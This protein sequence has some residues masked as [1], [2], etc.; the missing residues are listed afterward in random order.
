M[1]LDIYIRTDINDKIFTGNY[2]DPKQGY[3]NK[4]SL[5]RTFCNFMCRR[6]VTEGESELDQI[7]RITLVDISPIYQMENYGSDSGE[8]LEFLLEVAESEEER[9]HILEQA[10]QNKENLKGNLDKV[11]STI[12]LLIGKLSKINDLPSLLDDDGND[13]LGYYTYFIDF[14]IDKGQGYIDNNFGQDLR[15]FKRFLEFAKERGATTV[16]FDYG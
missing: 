1:G 6:N 10:K 13:T 3:Y 12:N 14:N 5:S 9:Q 8:E 11:L 2:H 15:N 4:H 16:Y 7:G